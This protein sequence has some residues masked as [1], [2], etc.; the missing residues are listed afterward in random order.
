MTTYDT[1]SRNHDVT[2]MFNFFTERVRVVTVVL[3][4]TIIGTSNS[5]FEVIYDH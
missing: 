2:A 1:A 5:T 3:N 4:L